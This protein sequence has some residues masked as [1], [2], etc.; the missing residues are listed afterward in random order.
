MTQEDVKLKNKIPCDR[1]TSNH[2]PPRGPLDVSNY[3]NSTKQNN[4]NVRRSLQVVSKSKVENKKR[5]QQRRST[6][7]RKVATKSTSAAGLPQRRLTLKKP[8]ATTVQQRGT[9]NV[10]S[11]LISYVMLLAEPLPY[12]CRNALYDEH[13]SSKQERGVTH[14]V[15]CC[16]MITFTAAFTKWLNYMLAPLDCYGNTLPTSGKKGNQISRFTQSLEI[17]L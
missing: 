11:N 15:V 12:A 7:V 2:G 1:T 16:V 13:W 9:K 3:V 6:D 17:R 10:K 8:A 4:K 14:N 5:I